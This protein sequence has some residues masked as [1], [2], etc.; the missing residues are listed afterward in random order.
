[1]LY[2]RSQASPYDPFMSSKENTLPKDRLGRLY[3]FIGVFGCFAPICT[4]LL[5]IS[6]FSEPIKLT[7][8]GFVAA[9][10]LLVC[11]HSYVNLRRTNGAGRIQIGESETVGQDSAAITMNFDPYT[12][13]ITDLPNERAL[14]I[15]LEHQLAECQRTGGE[16]NLS[17]LAI[18][19]KD[20]D[21]TRSKYDPEACERLLRFVAEVIHGHLRKMDFLARATDDEFLV[22]LPT[23][24]KL[25]ASEIAQ[26]IAEAF[27][28]LPFDATDDE[29][30]KV[31]I[32]YGCG[33]YWHDGE[34]AEQLLNAVRFEK[35]RER[36]NVP[37]IGLAI[38]K[39]YIN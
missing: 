1:V 15:V 17:V 13:P 20:F 14:N 38:V 12:D 10:S 18:D 39:D 22:V 16:R 9:F 25:A 3:L 11:A 36:C 5:A 27:S 23:A 34:T 37:A 6:N 30:L 35:A 24:D 8:V 32:S 26:R 28:D 31:R 2:L 33:S 19:V 7:G 4:F 21:E 29:Q